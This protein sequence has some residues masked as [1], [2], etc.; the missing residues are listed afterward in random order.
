VALHEFRLPH[1]VGQEAE[2]AH[3]VKPMQGDVQQHASQE[4]HGIERE[5]A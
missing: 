2:V 1:A 3:P 5:S 4:F